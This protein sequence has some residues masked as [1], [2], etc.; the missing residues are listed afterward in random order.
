MCLGGAK[1]IMTTRAFWT[2]GIVASLLGGGIAH[3]Q[4]ARAQFNGTVTDSAGR[5]QLEA[6]RPGAYRVQFQIYRW[7]PLVGPL[8]TLTEG[9]FKQRMYPLSFNDMLGQDSSWRDPRNGLADRENRDWYRKLE[10]FS[11]APNRT[12]PGEVVV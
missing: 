8:D 5:F 9:S 6:P 1:Q 10:A 7:E 12:A 4:G 3:A 2:L 11:G